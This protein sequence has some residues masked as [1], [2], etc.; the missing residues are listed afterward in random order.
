MAFKNLGLPVFF[1]VWTSSLL[2][3]PKLQKIMATPG[4]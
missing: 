4:F 3:W 2:H 1:E